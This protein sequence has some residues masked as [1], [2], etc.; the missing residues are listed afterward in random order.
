M[1]IVAQEQVWCSTT[2]KRSQGHDAAGLKSVGSALDVLECFATDGDLG[3]SDIARRLGVAKSTAHRLLQTLASRGF[4][5]QHADSGQY[6]LGIHLYELGELALARNTL[7]HVA[8]PFLRQV[9]T[10]TGLTTNLSV[11]D[12]PDVVFVE[13]IEN[14]DGVRM[15]GHFGRRLPAHTTSSGKA[16]AAFDHAADLARRRA[17]FPPRVSHTVRTEA[18][19]DR[20]L[21]Q[22]R[23]VGYAAS[24]SESFDGAS[25]VAVPVIV[26][27]TAI[28]AVS[29]F[30]PTEVIAPQVERLVP[31]LVAASRRIARAHSG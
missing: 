2:P 19:W 23:R 16:I 7:R 15:L 30:G 31:V 21:E 18:D 1:S 27:R 29:I 14:S 20:C 3:V 24:T 8:L 10:A 13:R 9:A 12:G 5:E 4:V 28:A 6:R 11:V 25:S 22:V 26:N 17:G